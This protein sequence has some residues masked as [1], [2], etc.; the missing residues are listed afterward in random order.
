VE[1]VFAGRRQRPSA[2]A[3]KYWWAPGEVLPGEG[4][5]SGDELGLPKRSRTLEELGLS[6]GRGR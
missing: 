2:G 4:G 1:E 6:K 5:V 3:V